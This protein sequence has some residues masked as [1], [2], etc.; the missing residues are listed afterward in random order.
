[1]IA[2]HPIIAVHLNT[3]NMDCGEALIYQRAA[4][5]SPTKIAIPKTKY[6]MNT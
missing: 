6:A 4:K 2:R 1:M 3:R 5:E